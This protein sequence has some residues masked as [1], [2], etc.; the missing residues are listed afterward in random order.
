MTTWS[1]SIIPCN[2]NHYY[3]GEFGRRI[4][5]Q[6]WKNNEVPDHWKPSV[7]SI[8]ENMPGWEYRLMT[9]ED[10]EKFIGHF[11]PDFLP[12]YKAFPYNIQRADAIRYCVMSRAAEAFGDNIEVIVYMDLDF[13]VRKPLDPIFDTE[14]AQA[15][16]VPSGNVTQTLTNSFMGGRPGAPIFEEC[17]KYMQEYGLKPEWYI[18]GK[19]MVVMN[20]TGPIMLNH[21]AI[22]TKTTYLK[23]PTKLFIPCSICNINCTP[24][25]DAYLKPLEG[26]SW[27]GIDSKF[28]NTCLCNSD[29][30]ITFLIIL[31][32]II[33]LYL[34]VYY[35]GWLK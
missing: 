8:Y 5:F 25:P 9:D 15:Y 31:I 32:L 18:M 10:N 13:I 30:L 7:A 21:V 23:V 33:F 35:I 11:F 22:N 28:Y 1:T 6:T 17:V 4:I 14:K 19:H 26:G 34:L 27:N 3:T 24:P 12:V 20:S 16:F 29:I 2:S